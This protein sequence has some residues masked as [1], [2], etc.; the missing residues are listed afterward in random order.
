MTSEKIKTRPPQNL[1]EFYPALNDGIQSSNFAL[2]LIYEANSFINNYTLFENVDIVITSDRQARHLFAN[3]IRELENLGITHVNLKHIS[4]NLPPSEIQ[5]KKQTRKLS[6][7]N[8]KIMILVDAINHGNEINDIVEFVKENGG[9]L[10]SIY[11]Y[12]I[13]KDTFERLQSEPYFKDI[14]IEGKHIVQSDEYSTIHEKFIAFNHTL[15]NPTDSEHLYARYLLAPRITKDD[16]NK[17]IIYIKNRL[18]KE[19]PFYSNENSLAADSNLHRRFTIETKDNPSIESIGIDEKIAKIASLER[20]QIRFN[21]NNEA[22]KHSHITTTVI[23]V[24][25]V[26]IE[27]ILKT[28]DCNNIIDSCNYDDSNISESSIGDYHYIIC[29]QCLENHIATAVHVQIMRFLSDYLNKTSKYKCIGAP[30]VQN[31]SFTQ[32]EVY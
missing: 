15:K 8:S 31:P 23:P 20:L 3:S 27:D 4:H 29:P 9:I 26:S 24:V 19:T 1:K 11:A 30:I 5:S 32:N 21:I 12:L 14:L 28:K 13:N 22:Q 16:T 7:P 18:S 2:E 17:M 25:D 10:K 6:I